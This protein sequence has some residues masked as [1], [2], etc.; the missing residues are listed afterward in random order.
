MKIKDVM[1][2]DVAACHR[3]ANLAEVAVTMWHRGCGCVP[4][5]N[6]D[7]RLEG[8]I[9][10]RDIAIA[11][12]LKGR[13]A[14]R[15]AV[16][17]IMNAPVYACGPDDKMKDVLQTMRTRKVRR[18]PVVDADGHL[19]G[20]L[21]VDDIVLNASAKRRAEPSARELVAA[22]QAIYAPAPLVAATE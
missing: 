3:N 20:I 4:V 14:D 18:V 10:D 19:K 7:G 1:T 6:E 15:I 11:V 21:S 9:T 16:A 8:M 12:G 22:L 13:A 2:T 17:E 5:V